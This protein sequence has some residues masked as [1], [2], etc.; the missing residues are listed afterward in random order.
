MKT[1]KLT[2][3]VAEASVMIAFATVLS[4]FKMV[5]MPYGGAVTLASMLP[6]L[7][8]SYRHGIKM[9]LISGFTY[10]V[11]Q[12][13]IGLN[14]LSYFTTWQSVVAVM[15]LDYVAAFTVIGVGGIFKNRIGVK[16]NTPKSKQR[17]EMALGMGIVCVIRYACHTIAG[18]TVW[19]GLSIPTEAALVYSLSYN[20]TYMIPEALISVIVC[21]WVG[22]IID[23][24]KSIP[25]RFLPSDSSE[26]AKR[27]SA[28]EILAR[29][30]VFLLLFAVCFGILLVAPH[31]QDVESGEFT[32]ENLYN[33][34]FVLLLSVCSLCAAVSVICTLI[35][36]SLKGKERK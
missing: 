18:A 9:G 4:I 22:E 31:L 24:S 2:K 23:F 25:V 29:I 26:G 11:I 33:V 5:E 32:F 6:I 30:P 14:N 15:L 35:S 1:N 10:S 27:G 21:V 28:C 20:A 3:Q 34:N 13:L 16:K 17:I 8:V 19:A 36:R 12:Q 7:I